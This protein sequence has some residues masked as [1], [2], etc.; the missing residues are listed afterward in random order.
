M[1][2]NWKFRHEDGNMKHTVGKAAKQRQRELEAENAEF[3]A[4]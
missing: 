2:N 1:K 4:K 3:K